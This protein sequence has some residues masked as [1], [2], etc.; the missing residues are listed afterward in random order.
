MTFV[1]EVVIVEAANVCPSPSCEL[2]GASTSPMLVVEPAAGFETSENRELPDGAPRD[3]ACRR[4]M[5]DI[6]VPDVSER[7]CWIFTFLD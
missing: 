3:W 2:E 7:F 4:A 1:S 6:Q 5:G